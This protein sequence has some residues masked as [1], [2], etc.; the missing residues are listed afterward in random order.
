VSLSVMLGMV[1]KTSSLGWGVRAFSVLSSGAAIMIPTV[2]CTAT[3]RAEESAK[4]QNVLPPAN[5]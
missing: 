1:A 2:W 5:Q 4:R 3:L